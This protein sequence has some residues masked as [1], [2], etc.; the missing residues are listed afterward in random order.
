[1]M[2][3]LE[4]NCYSMFSRNRLTN[5]RTVGCGVSFFVEKLLTAG[6]RKK[7]SPT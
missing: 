5:Y 1:M 3:A 6:Y 7:S 2:G 4:I